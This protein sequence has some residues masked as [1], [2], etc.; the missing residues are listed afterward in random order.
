[1]ARVLTDQQWQDFLERHHIVPRCELVCSWRWVDC[2][3]CQATVPV[4]RWSW[5]PANA[6]NSQNGFA[7]RDG[8]QTAATRP[9]ASA[10]TNQR[11]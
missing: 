5:W 6:P 3:Q 7:N 1:M 9:H 2:E 10:T 11:P 8:C 4:A